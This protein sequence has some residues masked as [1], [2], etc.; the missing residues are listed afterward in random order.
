ME[1]KLTSTLSD[2]FTME[3]GLRQGSVLSPLL[4]VVLFSDNVK[5]SFKHQGL[6]INTTEGEEDIKNQ[7]FVDD[8]ILLATNPIDIIGQVDSFNYNAAI[9]GSVL[10]IN[11]TVILSNRSTQPLKKWM[12][13]YDIKQDQLNKT[14][15]KYLGVWISIK[16]SS[17]KT[18]FK[19]VIDKS[20]RTMYFLKSRGVNKECLKMTE[21]LDI[22]KKL[23]LP[24]LTYAC[25]VIC[26]SQS[27]INHVNWFIA[28]IISEMTR[29]PKKCPSMSVIW[30]ANVEFFETIL[31]KAK[32]RFYFKIINSKTTT[33]KKYLVEGNYLY[34][35]IKSILKKLKSEHLTPQCVKEQIQDKKL[36]KWGWKQWVKKVGLE[37]NC[38]TIKQHS[39]QFKSMKPFP[40]IC[41]WLDTIPAKYA[42]SFY[43]AR[44]NAWPQMKCPCSKEP[45]FNVNLHIFIEC[46]HKKLMCDQVALSQY[47]DDLLEQYNLDHLSQ[48]TRIQ[49]LLGKYTPQLHNVNMEVIYT[50]AA[51]LCHSAEC[52]MI[53][54]ST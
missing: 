47:L 41:P 11:K 52:V 44:H 36:T 9:W 49:I 24:Q 2:S 15:A 12:E 14:S 31:A 48:V 43:I 8:T 50:M 23:I 54:L 18:H 28:S 16:N 32:L 39:I 21:T 6:P 30:E 46:T 53:K 1:V 35:E 22:M 51:K 33:T 38:Q 27:T 5:D 25:E 17:M 10:N 37:L 13:E 34:A 4:F 29:I 20:R 42:E 26:P 3:N 7:C 45:I 19:H 40:D